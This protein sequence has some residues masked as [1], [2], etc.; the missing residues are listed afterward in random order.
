MQQISDKPLR[1]ENHR[2]LKGQHRKFATP[3][4]HNPKGASF[5]S[6]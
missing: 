6:V 5:D 1:S 4:P 3:V 2:W